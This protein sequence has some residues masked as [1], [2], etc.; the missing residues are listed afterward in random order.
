LLVAAGALLLGRWRE[1]FSLAGVALAL[2]F[3]V[4]AWPYIS[5]NLATGNATYKQLSHQSNPA[6][7]L[8]QSAGA[9]TVG[10]PVA[11]GSPRVCLTQGNIWESYPPSMAI[12]AA[13]SNPACQAPNALISLVALLLLG[14]VGWQL[15]RWLW[16]WLRWAPQLASV[17]DWL[18]RRG[19]R[20]PPPNEAEALWLAT[21]AT[22]VANAR[23]W[24]RAMMLGIALMT[25]VLFF[26][27]RDAANFPFTSARYLMPLYLA[28]PLFFGAL[29]EAARP[30]AAR[31]WRT[32]RPSPKPP[33]TQ[34]DEEQETL[35]GPVT[36]RG[37]GSTRRMVV[38]GLAVVGLLWLLS[39]SLYGGA[40]T[41]SYSADA[42]RFGSPV[43]PVDRS[44]IAFFDAHQITAYYTN[45][46][47]ACYRVTFEANERLHCAIR[48]EVGK[49]N[50]K[51][52][53]NR[54]QP[55]VDELARMP[56]PAY[57]LT[58]DSV[59]DQQF[60]QLAAAE[61]LPHDGYQRSVVGGYAVYYFAG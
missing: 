50:L 31:V 26:T 10:L 56:H 16:R 57:L 39:S 48:G 42:T 15:G 35:V 18:A 5:F 43:L 11:A 22:A 23:R 32:V 29:W 53:A 17:R 52:N 59:Q 21:D 19:A 28:A 60:A 55:W 46:Y 38:T 9:L 20:T 49:P 40:Q 8:N 61:G 58:L 34:G 24:L 2:A 4:G 25:L 47:W 14:V 13:E 36:I 6:G 33:A 3:V 30:L 45:D 41:L 44:L 1:V 12:G 7:L 54:Y 51:L 37:S 27:S